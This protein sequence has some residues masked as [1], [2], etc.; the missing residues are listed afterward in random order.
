MGAWTRL[1]LRRATPEEQQ[2]LLALQNVDTAIQQL[3]HR[4]AH[5][6]E[7]Q[8]LDE[9]AA[10]AYATGRAA[11]SDHRSI[12]AEVARI[13]KDPEF[14]GTISDLGGPTA[15]MYRMRC[16]RPEV[17]AKVA[18]LQ[19]VCDRVLV[20]FRG[21]IAAELA[22]AQLDEDAVLRLAMGVATTTP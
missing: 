4:R 10:Q 16:T 5:L 8:A 9:M 2:R 17:E 18:E 13:A 19:Q 11:G 20:F 15:N 21:R 3:E 14:K 12:V 6:P 22:N 7:Q 1:V